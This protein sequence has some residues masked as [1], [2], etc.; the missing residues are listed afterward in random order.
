MMA[1]GRIGWRRLS[2]AGSD[3]HGEV[4]R[5]RVRIEQVVIDRSIAEDDGASFAAGTGSRRR[6]EEVVSKPQKTG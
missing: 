2:A 5:Q 4:A 3:R 1:I 6:L